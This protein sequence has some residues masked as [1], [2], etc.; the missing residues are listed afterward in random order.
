MTMSNKEVYNVDFWPNIYDRARHHYRLL[1]ALWAVAF[2]LWVPIVAVWPRTYTAQAV[3]APAN[4]LSTHYVNGIGSVVSRL[5]GG[6]IFGSS[7]AVS[8][9]DVYIEL[10]KSRKLARY[11]AANDSMMQ[12]VFSGQWDAKKGR[13]R[14][15][16]GVLS[17][18]SRWLKGVWGIPVEQHPT[19]DDLWGFIRQHL[20]VSSTQSASSA[21]SSI[22]QVSFTDSSRNDSQQILSALLN[23]ADKILRSS[24]RNDVLAR[25]SFLRNSLRNVTMTEQRHAL[26]SILAEQEQNLTVLSAD[27]RF[28]YA[29]LDPPSAAISPSSPKP[30]QILMLLMLLALACWG[31]V[32]VLGPEQLR[33]LVGGGA[34]ARLV[35][36][37]RHEE[38]SARV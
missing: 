8:P 24:H 9:F 33:A 1:F 34:K 25:I 12:V 36:Q 17:G 11:L 7:G 27:K 31:G 19:T 6:G 37:H 23:G 3:I 21:F 32:L 35:E 15:R 10:L 4:G 20:D 14:A 28:A 16:N 30:A 29:L 5:G 13:W 26:I 18:V 2:I 38:N 22:M